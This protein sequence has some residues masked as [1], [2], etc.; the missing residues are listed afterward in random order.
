M[1]SEK[2]AGGKWKVSL[3]KVEKEREMLGKGERGKQVCERR[4]ITAE[5]IMVCENARI[6]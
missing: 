4:E 5:N 3:K 6:A 2:K 1:K